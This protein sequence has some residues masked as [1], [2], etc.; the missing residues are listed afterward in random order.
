MARLLL[1]LPVEVLHQ[2]S[3]DLPNRDIKNLRRTCSFA[4]M[5]FRL[6]FNR[7]FLSP[8][9][10]DIDVFCE[11]ASSEKF[12]HQIVELFWDQSRFCLGNM[13]SGNTFDSFVPFGATYDHELA[14]EMVRFQRN[15]IANTGCLISDDLTAFGGINMPL[16]RIAEINKYVQKGREANEQSNND[17]FALEYHIQ[18]FP[19][20]RR[21]TIGHST[22]GCFFEPFYET[23]L[24]R[25][26]PPHLVY[27][28]ERSDYP[29]EPVQEHDFSSRTDWDQYSQSTRGYRA[30]FR[31]LAAAREL[32]LEEIVIE[33]PHGV[34]CG[35][36]FDFFSLGMTSDYLNLVELLRRPHLQRLDLAITSWNSMHEYGHRSHPPKKLLKDALRGATSLKNFSFKVDMAQN[37]GAWNL[38]RLK[39]LLPVGRWTNLRHFEL[40]SFSVKQDDLVSL[41]G[42]LPQ[43]IRS[44]ELSF[45][46]F[47][48]SESES[49]ASLLEEIRGRA[50]WDERGMNRPRLGISLRVG[51]HASKSIVIRVDAEIESFLYKQGMNPFRGSRGPDDVELGI[52]TERDTFNQCE[53][54]RDQ[55]FNWTEEID[56][57]QKRLEKLY[58]TG[59]DKLRRLR[60][61]MNKTSVNMYNLLDE[62]F[63]W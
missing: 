61:T 56:M 60:D 38:V 11:V 57:T 15:R 10:R 49:H 36:P 13:T 17:I 41:L 31:A 19:S 2:I 29:F 51:Q 5:V 39:T 30:I 62:D 34:E 25:S 20:L 50:L 9:Q 44:I 54:P 1:N 46:R 23:P 22:N 32:Q 59:E 48:S 3:N 53:W 26:F 7:I 63:Q 52:G 27:D 35:L 42:E 4:Q 8:H 45:L 43:S 47:R 18:S 58:K 16:S 21:V 28:I 14:T 12:R 6:R 40:S 55:N 24:V 37:G 33:T